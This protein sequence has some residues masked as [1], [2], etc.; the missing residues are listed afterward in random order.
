[1]GQTF[2]CPNGHSLTFGDTE[3]DKLRRER[4]RLAQRVAEKDDA[5]ARARSWHRSS[6]SN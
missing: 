2:Y 6:S 5:I 4:D 1:M 3:L